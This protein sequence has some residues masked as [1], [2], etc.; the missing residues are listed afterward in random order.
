MIASPTFTVFRS[1][2]HSPYFVGLRRPTV[3][4]RPANKRKRKEKGTQQKGAS[5][6]KAPIH[7]QTQLYDPISC[8][9][10]SA[11]PADEI[12]YFRAPIHYHI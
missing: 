8:Y 10:N 7:H 5:L 2:V 3:L 1:V 4:L 11:E 9:L 12:A 6:I